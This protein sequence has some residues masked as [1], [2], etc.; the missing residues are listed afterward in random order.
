[1]RGRFLASPVTILIQYIH[2]LQTKPKQTVKEERIPHGRQICTFSSV[3][4]CQSCYFIIEQCVQKSNSEKS[5][6][7]FEALNQYLAKDIHKGV[8][9][10]DF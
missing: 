1:M 3:Q 7:R 5:D 9:M 4:N 8:Y 2:V 6:V 10:I